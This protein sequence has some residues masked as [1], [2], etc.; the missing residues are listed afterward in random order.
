MNETVETEK[1]P[2]N[3]VLNPPE[4]PELYRPVKWLVTGWFSWILGISGFVAY[5][6]WMAL[7]TRLPAVGLIF[8]VAAG[9]LLR[10]YLRYPVRFQLIIATILKTEYLVLAG[11]LVLAAGLRFSGIRQSLPYLDNPDEPTL[12]NAAIKMLQTGDLNPHFFRWPSLPFYS[13]F[14]VSLYQF[15]SGVSSGAYNTLSGIIPENFYLS[16]RLLSATLGVGTVFLTYLLGRIL[17]SGGVGLLGALILSI[18]PLHSEHSKY[19]TPDIM[20]TFFAT[21]TLLF[22][23]L[24]YK[25]GHLRW[26]LWAGVATGLTAGSKYNVAIVLVAV[27]T[28]H[29]LRHQSVSENKPIWRGESFKLL[30]SFGVAASTF[31]VTTPFIILDLTGFLNEMAFQV[32]HYTIEGHGL[33]SQ[34]E[35]WKAYLSYFLNE[36]FV[37]QASLAA[38]GGVF[39]VLIRQRREDWLL[40]TFPAAGYLFFSSAIVHFPRNLLPLLPPL[41][42]LAACFLVWQ[43]G[44]FTRS[45]SPK[46]ALV[47]NIL[48]VVILFLALFCFSIWNSFLTTS[49]Y[50]QT[51]T[52]IEAGAWITT[53]IPEGSKMRMERFTPYLPANRYKEVAEQRPIGGRTLDW[54]KEQGYDYLVASSYEYRDLIA[55]DPQA[56]Q[57]YRL[58]FQQAQLVK[59][60]PGDSNAH[61][62]PTIRV[63]KVR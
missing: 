29:F 58:I 51:D 35:S 22:A 12:V 53:N 28:A 52:R 47:L 62:G 27:V 38:I 50:L 17:Y 33:N 19:I 55:N 20:V 1:A 4:T 43:A 10:L 18:L 59:E 15:V 31:L 44:I 13:Q 14:L 25:E 42:L 9:G 24:V 23:A 30:A 21:L 49:Y 2:Q 56:A 57:N 40:L 60:F 11:I 3:P 54:Y 7:P 63:Y 37:Y 61:P 5:I 6:L 39:L 32:R 48:C 16:G 41:A 36:A 34:G 45:L 46:K 8:L 26:Y